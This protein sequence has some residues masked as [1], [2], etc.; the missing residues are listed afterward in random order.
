MENKHDL[1]ELVYQFSR[2]I[3]L[4][5]LAIHTCQQGEKLKT[6]DVTKIEMAFLN[7]C[8]IKG[9]QISKYVRGAAV[10]I[11]IKEAQRIW[12][13]SNFNSNEAKILSAIGIKVKPDA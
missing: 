6:S 7:P 10:G 5:V 11:K 3:A 2:E 1:A 9:E 13:K 12:I 4:S 8:P